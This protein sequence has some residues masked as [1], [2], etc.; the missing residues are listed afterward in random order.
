MPGWRE[1]R[2][3]DVWRRCDAGIRVSLERA[4]RLRMDA[5]PLDYEALVAALGDLMAPLEAFGEAERSVLA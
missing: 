3:D 4:E 2:T 5:P 1:A